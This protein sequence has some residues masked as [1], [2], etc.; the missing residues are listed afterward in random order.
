[1]P[2]SG[3]GTRGM[4]SFGRFSCHSGS[5]GGFSNCPCPPAP[6]APPLGE[7]SLP[8][9]DGPCVAL[10]GRCSAAGGGDALCWHCAGGGEDA[11]CGR[12]GAGAGRVSDGPRETVGD[13]PRHDNG[14]CEDSCLRRQV[15]AQVISDQEWRTNGQGAKH[16]AAIRRANG[17]PSAVRDA[18][19]YI[20]LGRWLTPKRPRYVRKDAR[21]QNMAVEAL[22][23][24]ARA[25]WKLHTLHITGRAIACTA[26]THAHRHHRAVLTRKPL[27]NST[28]LDSAPRPALRA[29]RL[30][31]RAVASPETATAR[32]ADRW[33][34]ATCSSAV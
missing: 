11:A 29:P 12:P 6:R 21:A 2:G 9:D 22:G 33:P 31:L 27:G 8:G 34:F 32:R 25:L 1:M 19:K 17:G 13:G 20:R 18:F 24:C 15:A 16:R 7:R 28:D 3:A 30:P 23:S 14:R 4:P 5:G 26:A 10:F